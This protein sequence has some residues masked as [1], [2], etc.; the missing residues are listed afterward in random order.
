MTPIQDLTRQALL[1]LMLA[2]T[3]GSSAVLAAGPAATADGTAAQYKRWIVEMKEQP[4]GPFSGI[5][6]FC[7]DG[8]VLA[9][10]DYAC[11]AKGQGWQHGE[12]SD[13]TRQIRAQ[14]YLVANLLAGLDVDK[15]LADP[16]F[17]DAYAQWLVEKFL[18]S[19]DDGWILR[20]AQYYRGAV[21]EE[22]ERDTAR[23]L[24]IGMAGQPA[25]IGHRYV[26]LRTGARL[27]PHGADGASAQKVRNLAAA[28]NDR[29][30]GF[31]KL[32]IKIH[33]SPEA[34]DAE[35]V[36]AW[37]ASAKDPR[38]AE[39]ARALAAEID[40]VY[41][42]R[43]FTQA[44]DAAGKELDADAALK[45]VLQQARTAFA[46]AGNAEQRLAA[47][48]ALLRQLRDVLP[49]VAAGPRR[50][51]A[52]DLSLAAEAEHFRAAAE[53][54][55]ADE[56][57][58]KTTRAAMI[59]RL[60]AGADAAYG[61][62]LI[63]ARARAELDKSWARFS[64]DEISLGDHLAALRSLGL[65][66]A[67]G[68]Q[69]LRQ[70]FGEAMDK[71][72]AIE[73]MADLFIQDQ[74]RGSPLLAYSQ[75]L[76]ALARDANRAAGVQH[77]L[78][79]REIGAGFTALNPGLARGVL[80]ANPDMK[81]VG[82]LRADGIYLLPETVSEL[83]PVAGILTAGA[84]NP[85]S[86]VQLLAR[87]LGIPNVAVDPAL[88]PALRPLDGK[89]IVLAVS[90]AGLVEVHEDGPKWDATFGTEAGKKPEQAVMFAPDLSKLDLKQRDLVSLDKLRADDS[91][92]T[93]GPKAA[94]LG[95]LKSRFPDRVVGGVGLPFGLYR[96][97]VLDKP[98]KGSGKTVY[99]WMVESFRKLEALPA[100]S[101][102]AARASEALRAEI[103]AIVR[104]T[105]PGPQ[106]RERLR[107]AMAREFG[108]DF[109]GG[110]FIRSDTNVEDLPGFTGAG[111]NLTL[112]NVA[113][114]DNIVKGI[115]EV[116]ASPYTARA[117]AWRQSHMSGP[118]HVYPAVMLMRTVPAE[119]SGVM[120]TQDVDSGD[121]GVLSVAVNEG[122]GGAV[123][124]QAAESVRITRSSGDVRLMAVATAPRKLVPLATGG[125][126][127]QPVSGKDT[128]LGPGE[129]K[130][131][132]AFADQ[133]PKQFPQFGEDGKPVAADVEF[134]FVGGTLGLLQIRPFNESRQARGASHLAAMDKGLTASLGK[135]VNL[136]EA[137]Q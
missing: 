111:L 113:G 67:W 65:L 21:Q 38:L 85:L 72:T 120:V 123:D 15:A 88:L 82:G 84:G 122:V 104:N 86:H 17:P 103:Y 50:L 55:S 107:A 69:T 108:A 23:R 94:K 81:A 22:D 90:P 76:D 35:A 8:R 87:N 47:S 19:A 99:E 117:W 3:M 71:L 52:L 112:F 83:P 24:L 91:G 25:W 70:H 64:V 77:R 5:K 27:L 58:A 121:A 133:I 10:K 80:Y 32:R 40:R 115:A 2:C 34:A 33:N 6:W 130:Q 49:Q 51:G 7:R 63:G 9:P 20:K 78:L 129:V 132:I 28:L 100:G 30:A 95:E 36:R 98:Y 106:F 61:S 126:A 14:G 114:F 102:E 134:S 136:K 57:G 118:E 53:L 109:K 4:R 92:R 48:A 26:A 1:S 66:P 135:R 18:V 124:G 127:R 137:L 116:W 59:A 11:A 128:L 41:A 105:D 62:G 44:L 75:G 12:W 13:R 79:G 42:P 16:G 45:P 74:L 31:E 101:A 56:K 46:A 96:A 43:P 68:S 131:L 110:V 73:P 60:K 39:Q 54:R 29:D 89:R 37:A 93:V 119:V 125:V 97:A